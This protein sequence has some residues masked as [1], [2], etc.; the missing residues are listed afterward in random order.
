VPARR[1]SPVHEAGTVV[2]AQL[3]GGPRL[4]DVDITDAATAGADDEVVAV[5]ELPSAAR[6]QHQ[7]ESAVGAQA[8]RGGPIRAY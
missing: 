3:G 2:V 6:G 8:V 5:V 4:G 1:G 7:Q